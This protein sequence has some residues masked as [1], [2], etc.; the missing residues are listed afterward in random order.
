MKFKDRPMKPVESALW[1][2]EYV[3]RYDDHTDLKPLGMHQNW[4]VRR[5]LDVW[6][7]VGLVTL[8]IVIIIVYLMMKLLNY[9]CRSKTVPRKLKVK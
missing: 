5:S 8:I 1:W 9:L 6:A 2:T 4:F 7:F 3:L